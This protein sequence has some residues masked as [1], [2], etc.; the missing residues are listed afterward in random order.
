MEK[1]IKF[2]DIPIQKFSFKQIEKKMKSYIEQLKAAPDFETGFK[3]IKAYERFGSKM[4]TNF[5]IISVRF[6]LNTQDEVITKYQDLV[7]EI[8]PL[9]S[10]LANEW[11]KVLVALPYR[12]QIEEKYGSYYFQMIENE[13]KSFDEKIIP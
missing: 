2:E 7:D 5:G 3:V 4:G 13:L 6:T 11:N 12:K 9:I 10:N 1:T 8:S